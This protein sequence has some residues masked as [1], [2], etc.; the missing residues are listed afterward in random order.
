MIATLTRPVVGATK[1]LYRYVG[2]NRE[3][4][5]PSTK[6]FRKKMRKLTFEIIGGDD[7]FVQIEG[8]DGKF[9]SWMPLVHLE[10]ISTA[11]G[12]E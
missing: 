6:K 2:Q 7:A 8:S 12:V 5:K 3:I 10:A 11:G 1:T 9:Y 4:D